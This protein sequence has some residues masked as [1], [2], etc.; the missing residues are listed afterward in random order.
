MCRRMAIWHL[1]HLGCC[2]RISPPHTRAST[3]DSHLVAWRIH[4][5]SHPKVLGTAMGGGDAPKVRGTPMGKDQPTPQEA[6]MGKDECV[7]EKLTH[8]N[9]N[10]DGVHA[11]NRHTRE[12]DELDQVQG[13]N[14][15]RP[16]QHPFMPTPKGFHS[17]EKQVHPGK[18][19][20]ECKLH[21][22]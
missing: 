4:R 22:R 8:E 6:P 21:S 12:E 17:W 3:V 9:P 11:W 10:T 19:P 16:K 7:K 5:W 18:K 2:V 13:T 15:R 20:R 1:H 14:T